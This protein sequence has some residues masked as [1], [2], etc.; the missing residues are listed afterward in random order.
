MLL[1]L[2]AFQLTKAQQASP[3]APLITFKRG[4]GLVTPDSTFSI[5]FRFRMQNRAIYTS[6]SE[7]NLTPAEFEARVRRLRLR[8][9]G[10]MY[11]PT[12]TY[13]IQLS[14][15][16]GDMDWSGP[17]NS[18][19]NTS[20]NVV[21][22]AAITYRPNRHFSFVFGQTKLPG[23]R[24][25]VISSGEQ[26]FME[27]SIVNATFTL[28]RD[29]GFQ[30]VYANTL[31]GMAY[32]LKGAISTGEGRNVNLTDRGLMYTGRIEILP[33]GPFTNEGDYF[34]GD[35]EREPTP[36]LS[37]AGGYG[38]NENAVR[39]GGQLGKDLFE[40]RDLKSVILDGLFKYQ[41]WA[42]SAEYLSRDTENPL[43]AK[44]VDSSR[45]VYIG[46]GTNVQLSYYFKNKIEVV[47]R[48][49]VITPSQAIWKRENEVTHY[50]LGVT[51]YLRGHRVK[52]QSNLTYQTR[53]NLFTN[54][55]TAKNWILGCQ[56]EL[57]I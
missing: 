18:A 9:N 5:N 42:L 20:P 32:Q 41:G 40:S 49:A 23:N 57:G 38:Y 35:L 45:Y 16:R 43:T 53:K 25:R 10:F 54:S 31:A 27:R 7:S 14:F 39:S 36:K 44:G 19:S 33:F 12:L 26:Q 24:Q 8:F 4:I 15:S 48:Y 6:T 17:D 37:L 34:E 1:F 51:K 21:R 50:T 52:L 13:S 55:F 30:T 56:I 28:D 47:G 3:L 11:N 2:F 22:D 29:F 46:H